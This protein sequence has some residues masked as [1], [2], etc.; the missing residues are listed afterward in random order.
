MTFVDPKIKDKKKEVTA[1]EPVKKEVPKYRAK[2]VGT[3]L[4][5]VR[6]KPDGEEIGVIRDG[7]VVKVMAEEGDWSKVK[8]GDYTDKDGYVKTEFLKNVEEKDSTPSMV[9]GHVIGR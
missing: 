6:N 5:R 7:Y 9:M 1:E 8:W 2:V 3:M 4:L